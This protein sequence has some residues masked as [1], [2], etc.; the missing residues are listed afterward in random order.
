V[1]THGSS[2]NRRR[3]ATTALAVVTADLTVVAV[4]PLQLHLVVG[5]TATTGVCPPPPMTMVART[6]HVVKFASR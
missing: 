6:V 3:G 2:Q 1:V 5:T 4:D